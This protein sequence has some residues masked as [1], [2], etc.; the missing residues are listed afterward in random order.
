MSRLL[1]KLVGVYNVFHV[2]HIRKCLHDSNSMVDPT[3]LE[4]VEVE[5]EASV[6]RIPTKIVGH[7]IKKL[8]NREVSFVRFN[9]EMMLNT[10]RGQLKRR[11]VPLICISLIV[12]FRIFYFHL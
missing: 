8:G 6:H 4:E 3:Q 1:E 11:F 2:S 9:E 12:G 7:D 5:R 10:L